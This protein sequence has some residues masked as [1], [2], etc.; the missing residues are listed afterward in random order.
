M[1]VEIKNILNYMEYGQVQD[2]QPLRE[3][4]ENLNIENTNELQDAIDRLNFLIH[5]TTLKNQENLGYYYL[6]L[7]C[8]YQ[9]KEEL[10]SAASNLQRAIPELRGSH[11][12][13]VVAHY[14][15]SENYSTT[16]QYIKAQ[17]E[18]HEALKLLPATKRTSSYLA[19]K[20]NQTQPTLKEKINKRLEDLRT[21]TLFDE[22][23]PNPNPSP[24]KKAVDKS[25]ENSKT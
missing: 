5:H 8:V 14:L 24:K 3:R 9:E 11:N 20:Q 6:F 21:K 1:K 12:N 10:N 25:A 7:G 2:I 15:L 13:K 17:G 18:L 19:Y 16:K 23:P 4:I 22:P